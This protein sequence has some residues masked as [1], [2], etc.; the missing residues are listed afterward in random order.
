MKNVKR[1]T[2]GQQPNKQAP[3]VAVL[4]TGRL[5]DGPSD[6]DGAR[7]EKDETEQRTGWEE[8]VPRKPAVKRLIAT[9]GV[10]R[11]S[12]FEVV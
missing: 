3:R 10:V 7:D 11:R 9:E 6:P 8:K 12:D 4:R 2:F 1:G 5:E